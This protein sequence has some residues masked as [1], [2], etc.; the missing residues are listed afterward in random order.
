MHVEHRLELLVGHLL[1]GGVP[2][3]AG[4][5]DDDVEAAELLERRADEPVGEP[6]L[7]DVAVDR[8][9]LGSERLDLVHD[10]G[11]RRLVEIVDHDLRP[12]PRQLQ[13]DGAADAAARARYESDFAGKIVHLS[14]SRI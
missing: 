1:D 4:V 11:A 8:D 6:G 13:R 7:G 10:G 14:V 3:V 12:V 9:R 2:G 5:V